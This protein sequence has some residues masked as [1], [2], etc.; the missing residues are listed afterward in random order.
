MDQSALLL[1]V[2]VG[3]T[4]APHAI[5]VILALALFSL[6]KYHIETAIYIEYSPPKVMIEV[7]LASTKPP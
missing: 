6:E 7:N 3:V 1:L 2:S 5:I 4:T